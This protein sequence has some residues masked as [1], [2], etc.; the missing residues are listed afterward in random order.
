MAEY[1][2]ASLLQGLQE[3]PFSGLLFLSSYP[4]FKTERAKT[5]HRLGCTVIYTKAQEPTML[6]VT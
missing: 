1:V 3:L 2:P 4:S 6:I 5:S